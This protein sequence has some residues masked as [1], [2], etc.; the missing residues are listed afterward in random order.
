MRRL[1]PQGLKGESIAAQLL[2]GASVTFFISI[3]G[4]ALGAIAQVTLAR[5]VG[6]TIYGQ[7]TYVWSWL[8]IL[9]TL[10]IVGMDTTTM[11]FAAS[12]KGQQTWGLLCGFLRYSYGFTAA[13]LVIGSLITAV[14]VVWILP[15]DAALRQTFIVACLA[16]PAAGFLNLVSRNLLAFEHV[17]M[18]SA[19]MSVFRP[20]LLLVGIG[21]TLVV[22]GDITAAWQ[23]IF[24]NVIT[25]YGLLGASGW[26]LWRALPPGIAHSRAECALSTW[27]RV[28][29]QLFSMEVLRLIVQ[30][31]DLILIGIFLGTT[32]AGIYAATTHMIMLMD[33][34]LY[35]LNSIVAPKISSLYG[36]GEMQELQ[37]MVTLATMVSSA[38]SLVVGLGLVVTGH[39]LLNLFGEAFTTGYGVLV[40][41]SVG[42][43]VNS[44]TGPVVLLMTM[45]G[46]Q[47]VALKLLSVNA[48][49]S[50]LL[51]ITLIPLFGMVGAAL[52]SSSVVV[53]W[54]LAMYWNVRQRLK[55]DPTFLG[56]F[57]TR[58]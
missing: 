17:W 4:T 55:I 36:R 11:R 18:A 50:V 41:L 1:V 46:H 32:K 45:T 42:R 38:Y 21:V 14:V 49:L 15:L 52:A 43:I 37:R 27:N 48:V 54:N 58:P 39:L 34:G 6:A 44:W 47:A 35:A 30:R 2:R 16:L 53:I 33:I 23:L 13:A 19:P 26:V 28:S 51:N 8:T 25:V 10:C 20:I 56:W 57:A 3:T 22:S 5:L 24:I 7:Y 29:L 12:Y 31:T 40:V 9:A